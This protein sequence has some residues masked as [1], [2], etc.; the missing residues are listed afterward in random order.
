MSVIFPDFFE[1]NNYFIDEKLA[2]FKFTNAYRVY[3][4][5]GMEIG[6]IRQRLSAG[7]KALRLLLNKAMLPFMLEVCDMDGNVLVTIR[8]GWT[9]WMSKITLTDGFGNP[10][11]S[12]KQKFKFLK[13]TFKILD[14]TNTEIADITGDW[15]G[16]N[17]AIVDERQQ[18]IG[19]ITKKWNGILKEAF[20]TADK[21]IVSIVPEYAE[22]RRKMA[23]VS[24]AITID[25]VLKE[26]K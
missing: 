22:N 25:M 7:Q 21:Y 11:G 6:L 15:K 2:F 26:S 18:N 20:T 13:P 24:T 4:E 10:V 12:I 5:T 14:E 9:F 8:R 19:T 23:I 1:T 17:F 16:W 3:D